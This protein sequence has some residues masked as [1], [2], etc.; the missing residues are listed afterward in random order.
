MEL[1]RTVE[2]KPADTKAAT[3]PPKAKAGGKGKADAAVE[4][5]P[6]NKKSTTVLLYRDAP[7][8]AGMAKPEG[9]EYKKARSIPAI[10]GDRDSSIED[11]LR[12]RNDGSELPGAGCGLPSTPVGAAAADERI[13]NGSDD[14]EPQQTRHEAPNAQGD[15][16]E[17]SVSTVAGE[18][19]RDPRAT[20]R[21]VLTYDDSPQSADVPFLP[22]PGPRPTQA[23]LE[24]PTTLAVLPHTVP[25]GSS[26]GL[27]L[28][29]RPPSSK[30][31]ESHIRA[32]AGQLVRDKGKG[33]RQDPL[34]GSAENTPRSLPS[35]EQERQSKQEVENVL[36]RLEG[37]CPRTI[38]VRVR[39][40][41]AQSGDDAELQATPVTEFSTR[42]TSVR[43]TPITQF[44]SRWTRG[45]RATGLGSLY[46]PRTRH[47]HGKD[48]T[49]EV[50]LTPRS[51][52][53]MIQFSSRRSSTTPTLE[54]PAQ[55]ND[56]GPERWIGSST[57]PSVISVT[58]VASRKREMLHA[59]SSD[60]EADATDAVSAPSRPVS[61]VAW[62]NGDQYE[63]MKM[64][65][66]GIR[67]MALRTQPNDQE[68]SPPKDNMTPW[69]LKNHHR[70]ASRR[71]N[72]VSQAM[73]REW[74]SQILGELKE[75]YCCDQIAPEH[76]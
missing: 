72:G 25:D 52:V 27:G 58:S 12:A 48:E 49:G 31:G 32:T 24:P 42:S 9:G 40:D 17:S 55:I 2:E 76:P 22:K 19:K 6:A 67:K 14:A 51:A 64:P 66:S 30:T 29:L 36:S 46:S 71:A 53:P 13:L 7:G 59:L 70:E 11:H 47:S 60:D 38:E 26:L 68:T 73:R 33:P 37:V 23:P 74:A 20:R 18:H 63:G 44:S 69:Q 28:T 41:G 57:A 1:A 39:E 4:E 50:N 15:R 5:D 65:P 75:R 54:P 35:P 61:V 3:M 62:S 10:I 16:T 21:G 34:S 56:D 43:K 45:A 8:P